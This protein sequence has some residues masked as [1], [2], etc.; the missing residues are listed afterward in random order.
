MARRDRRR[1]LTRLDKDDPDTK[2]DLNIAYRMMLRWARDA[3]LASDPPMPAPLRD[4]QA[5]NWRP[6]IAIA[7]AFGADWSTRAREAAVIFAGEHQDEDDTVTLLRDIR[8]IFDARGA[9]RLPSQTM[10]DHLTATDDAPWSEWR[11]IHGNQQPRMLS[12]GDLAR[13]LDP[14]QIRPRTIRIFAAGKPTV[15]GYYRTQFEAAWRSYCKDNVTPSQPKNIKY[16][17]TV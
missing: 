10:V 4:R 16:L 14:F 11:G 15:K 3:E 13:L 9:E 7:D 12:Q 8:D 17:R 1:Q 2:A 6:L 5:D